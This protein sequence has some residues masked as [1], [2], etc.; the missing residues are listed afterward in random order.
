VPFS[1]TGPWRTQ[2]SADAPLDPNSG[3][4]VSNVVSMVHQYYGSAALN[5]SSYSAPIYTVSAS[6]PTVNMSWNNCQNKSWE[7]PAFAAALQNVPIPADA[8][9]SQGTDAEMVIWQPSSDTEWEFWVTSQTDGTWS[10]CWG[11]MIQDVSQNPGI[12]ANGLGATGSGLPLLG[13][14]IRVADLRSGAINHAINLELPVTRAGAF[15]WPAQRT[16]GQSSNASEPAEG[17]RFRLPASLNLSQFNLSPGELMI[18][19][20]MQNYGLI[21]TDTSGAVTLQGEDP[22]PYEVNGASNPYDA[23]F[24]G[25][26]SQWLAGLP[27]QDLQAVAWNDGKPSS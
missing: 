18:A 17:E 10:A 11:G 12:F 19:R 25:S 4:I 24:S 2:L 1:A 7:A 21:V 23:Y 15:S 14:L 16:D 13:G 8:V 27:W 26:G 6:Q 9:P 22:R 3:A 20:A 5:T